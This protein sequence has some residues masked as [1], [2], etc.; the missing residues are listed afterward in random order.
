MALRMLAICALAAILSIVDARKSYIV[1]ERILT[2]EITVSQPRVMAYD[3]T[4]CFFK[5][6]NNDFC[7]SGDINWKL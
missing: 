4:W 5:D 3:C 6:K 7:V 2:G 1:K